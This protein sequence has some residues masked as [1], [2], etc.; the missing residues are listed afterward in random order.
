MKIKRLVC[1]MLTALMLGLCACAAAQ[2]AVVNNGADLTSRLNL[3]DRPTT[4]GASLGKFYSGTAVEVLADAGGGW[5]QVM[6]GGGMHSLSGYMMASYLAY[7]AASA[8]DA[9]FEVTV[10]SPYGT[11]SVVLRDD[12]SDSFGAVAMLA[13]GET[14][15]VIGV[16]G[17]YYYVQLADMT[18]GCLALDEVQ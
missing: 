8:P 1:L 5:A 10:V 15:R 2:P 4:D 13:V 17:E 6:I 12:P 7:D 14:V 3:R 16:S 18:V 11:Q 9:T